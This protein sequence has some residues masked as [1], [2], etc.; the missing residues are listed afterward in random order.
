[1]FKTGQAD[2]SQ[3]KQGFERIVEENPHSWN[4]NNYAKFACLA[5]DMDTFQSLTE[6]LGEVNL[7]AFGGSNAGYR[8]CLEKLRVHGVSPK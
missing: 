7:E 5:D 3:M 4:M 1:M 8:W 2:W 6:S